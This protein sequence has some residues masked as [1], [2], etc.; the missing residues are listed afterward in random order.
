[1]RI[2][3]FGTGVV[4]QTIG[5]KLVAIGHEVRMGSRSADNENAAKW[6]GEAGPEAS[7][8][9]FAD[10]ASFGELLFNCTAGLSSL[11][12]LRAAGAENLGGKVVVDLSNAL[13]VSHGTP[14]KVGLGNEDSVGEQLQREFPEARVVKTLNT[15]NCE[16]MVDPSKVPGEHNMFVCGND[17]SAKATVISL[18]ESFGWP[19]THVLDLGDITAAR[20]IEL[21]LALWLRLWGV[22]Q[23]PHFNI[24]LVR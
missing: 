7:Q 2:G 18:L 8:G 5:T 21:Y 1:M 15:V 22:A 17:E 19:A 4:G 12:A 13:D 3:V 20:G 9:T 23:T 11:D 24:R 14:P 16:V 10:A 6:A